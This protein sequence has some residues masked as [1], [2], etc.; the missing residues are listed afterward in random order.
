[1]HGRVIIRADGDQLCQIAIQ[2]DPTRGL[3]L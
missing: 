2:H 1:M 3:G